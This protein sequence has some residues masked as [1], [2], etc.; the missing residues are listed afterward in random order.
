M[1]MHV[2]SGAVDWRFNYALP[3]VDDEMLFGDL[4]VRLPDLSKEHKILGIEPPYTSLNEMT[5][6]PSSGVNIKVATKGFKVF[7]DVYAAGG[8]VITDTGQV[9][10]LTGDDNTFSNQS[11]QFMHAYVNKIFG[12]IPNLFLVAPMPNGSRY[13]QLCMTYMVA[14]VLGMLARY[15]PTHWVSLSQG[16]KGDAL[17]PT[18][19]QAHRLVAESFPELVAE[20]IEDILAHPL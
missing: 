5:Y 19:N 14:F 18:L 12:A 20:M 13:S 3:K 2:R 10:I 16:D 17:W 11:P 15:F 1:S 6:T 9:S 8:Y 7:E 4:M